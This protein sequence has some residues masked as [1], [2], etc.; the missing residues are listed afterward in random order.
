MAKDR[1]SSFEVRGLS[2][3]LAGQ[4]TAHASQE[5]ILI[6]RLITSGGD[7][8][9]T[10]RNGSFSNDDNCKTT[11]STGPFVNLSQYTFQVIWN[12]WN[13]D[14][15]GAPGNPCSQSNPASVA[16]HDLQN[17]DPVVALTCRY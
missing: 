14:H 15:V 5:P 7:D 1:Y 8:L 12:F 3:D 6:T 9:A 2:F 4:K 16:T 13:Q 10:S 11:S 17:H